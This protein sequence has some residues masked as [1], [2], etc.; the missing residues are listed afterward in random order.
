[1]KQKVALALLGV[2]FLLLQYSLWLGHSGIF[3]LHRLDNLIDEKQALVDA[4]QKR[5]DHLIAE[6]NNLKQGNEALEN[7]ARQDL[8]MV[9]NN[10]SF[11]QIVKDKS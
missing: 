2:I 7:H 5:N 8:G 4:A 6:I 3:A 9:K 11:Y 1:M 10:E